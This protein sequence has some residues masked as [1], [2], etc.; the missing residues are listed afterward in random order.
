MASRNRTVTV[1]EGDLLEACFLSE[2]ALHACLPFLVA[3]FFING[4]RFVPFMRV[5]CVQVPAGIPLTP[6]QYISLQ[7]G[8]GKTSDVIVWPRPEA[9]N[10][11][12]ARYM[13]RQRYLAGPD[14]PSAR[15]Y[16]WPPGSRGAAKA[17]PSPP[18]SHSPRRPSSPPVSSSPSYRTANLL[19][20][21]GLVAAVGR[22]E[23]RLDAA[24]CGTPSASA[25]T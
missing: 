2:W 17:P 1:M 10:F 16:R 5:S 8:D 23:G 12:L 20:S 6:T 3:K 11:E 21:T 13:V 19:D 15:G 18:E 22:L 4:K 14:I 24:G 7:H 9:A 25:L